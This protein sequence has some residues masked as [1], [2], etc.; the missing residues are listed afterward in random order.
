MSIKCM[1]EMQKEIAR[2]TAELATLKDECTC[3]ECEKNFNDPENSGVAFCIL[4]WNAMVTKL[5][6]KITK[7]ES[8]E[9]NSWDLR[10]IDITTGGDDYD[11]SWIVV[12]H[13]QA[14]PR[15]RTVGQG[16]TPSEAIEQAL[17]ENDG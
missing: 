12:E 8:L 11:I 15:E 13:Y 17:K 4:C 2:L 14:E 7:F 1:Q 6:A 16:N 5:R 10:C 9:E 3:E